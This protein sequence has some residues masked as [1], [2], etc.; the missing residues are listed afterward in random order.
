MDPAKVSAVSDWAVPK[1]RKQ[2]QRFLGFANFYRKF[3][4]GF[5]KVA[6]SMHALTSSRE[7]FKWT[8]EADRDFT[9]LD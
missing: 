2:L 4:R 7:R 8:E 1:D 6:A 5:S 9:R 3:I